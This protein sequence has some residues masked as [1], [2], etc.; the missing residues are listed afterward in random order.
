MYECKVCKRRSGYTDVATL[1]DRVKDNDLIGFVLDAVDATDL[2]SAHVN[3]RGT[4]S[5]EYPPGM[6][7]ALLIDCYATGVFRSHRIENC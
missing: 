6:M 3:H 2:R 4:G 5:A 7:L 1:R